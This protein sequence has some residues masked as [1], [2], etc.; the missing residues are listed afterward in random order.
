MQEVRHTMLAVVSHVYGRAVDPVLRVE[1]ILLHVGEVAVR[2][3]RRDVAALGLVVHGDR[4]AVL[5]ERV[6]SAKK[7]RNLE[8]RT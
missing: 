6:I 1:R 3:V 2:R 8:E 4:V 5:G 7:G